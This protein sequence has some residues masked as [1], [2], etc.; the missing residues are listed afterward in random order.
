MEK[1]SWKWICIRCGYK[2]WDDDPPD[3]CPDCNNR[4]NEWGEL[5]EPPPTHPNKY[6]SKKEN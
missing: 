2:E 1:P 5:F 6:K 3:V 4:N